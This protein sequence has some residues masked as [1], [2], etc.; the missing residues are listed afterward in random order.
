MSE[1]DLRR[2]RRLCGARPWREG[3]AGR[4]A[5]GAEGLRFLGPGWRERRRRV[6][7]PQAPTWGRPEEARPSGRGGRG[8]RCARILLSLPPCPL[9]PELGPSSSPASAAARQPRPA[10]SRRPGPGD[11][12][13]GEGASSLK[14]GGGWLVGGAGSVVPLQ[15]RIPRV[16]GSGCPRNAAQEGG[17]RSGDL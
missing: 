2:R 3:E 4:A 1:A 9:P 15:W 14:A 16:N 13:G 8:L 11:R 17:G 5:G 7:V 12:Q 6:G 10:G